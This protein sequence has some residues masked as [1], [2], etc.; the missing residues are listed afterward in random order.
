MTPT[1]TRTRSDLGPALGFLAPNL[2]GFVLF[3][4]GPVLFSLVAAFTNWNLDHSAPFAFT[5]VE[6]F[7]RM[8]HDPEF[9]L[10]SVNT[11]YLMIGI[12]VSIAGSLGLA[13]LLNQNLRGI[14]AY[15]TFFY[16]PTFT[17]GVALMILWKCLYNPDFGPIN[18]ILQWTIDVSHVN[19]LLA[20]LHLP[21]LAPPDWLSSTHN[22]L[23]LPVERVGHDPS[24]F[25]VGARDAIVNMGVWTAVGG[26]NML[27]YLAALSNIPRDLYEAAEIDGAGRWKSFVHITWPQL[28]PTTFFIIVISFIGGLQGGF[29]QARIMT[30]GKPANTTVSLTYYI[31][32]KAFEQFQMGYASAISWVLFS[33]IFV[34]TLV[35]WRL[36][37]SAAVAD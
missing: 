27:L 32:I 33:V 36:G 28:A 31:Y 10:Y 26:T 22:L 35:N 37:K 19:A 12:P 7:T 24:Q 30:Q 17:S 13:L 6:N 11:V 14:T 4:A 34:I 18:T 1:R 21:A 8:F 25:G 5:G 23:A 29:E 2:L 9:W 20:A 15:R 3:T 16:L